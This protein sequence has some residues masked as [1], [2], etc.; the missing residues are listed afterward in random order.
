MYMQ[1][2]TAELNE[3]LDALI[4]RINANASFTEIKACKDAIIEAN[5]K[6][7]PHNPPQSKTI[8][9]KEPHYY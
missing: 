4:E 8:E 6:T 7:R 9:S 5:A 2:H 1:N 3:K